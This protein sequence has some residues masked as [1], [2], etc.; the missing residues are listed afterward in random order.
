MLNRREVV[1]DDYFPVTKDGEPGFSSTEGGEI[2]LP[3]LEK[4]WAKVGGK[5]R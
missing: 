2:W 4:A 1:V 5:G 3:L